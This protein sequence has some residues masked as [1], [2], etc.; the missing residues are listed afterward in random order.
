MNRVQIGHIPKTIAAKLALYMDN[1]F[2]IVEATISGHKE[3]YE[4]PLTIRLYGP[5]DPQTRAN[6]IQRMRN[7][8]FPS[9]CWQGAT[10][11]EKVEKERQKV[12][13]QAAKKAMK[14]K[15]SGAVVGIGE[16]QQY[17]NGMARYAAGSSQGVG[18]GPSLEDIIGSSQHLN[19][20]NAEQIVEDFGVK[21]SDLVSLSLR[22]YENVLTATGRNAEGHPT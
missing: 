19:P 18:P 16:G 2:L 17:E 7:D 5:R 12:A 1:R 15:K 6:L 13:A 3:Y 21:E 14:D 20:R 8:K 11:M 9:S 22:N 4:C 10:Q